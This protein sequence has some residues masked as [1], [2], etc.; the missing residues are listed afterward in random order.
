METNNNS[1]IN[2]F[3]MK[4][5]IFSGSFYYP[6]GG[7]KDIIGQKDSLEE[8]ITFLKEKMEEDPESYEWGQIYSAEEGRIVYDTTE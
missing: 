6:Q 3:K 2:H 5:L 7:A 1:N 8:S 4:Y